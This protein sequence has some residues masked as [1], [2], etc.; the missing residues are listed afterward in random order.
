M[1][2][3]LPSLFTIPAPPSKL[4]PDAYDSFSEE[5]RQAGKQARRQNGKPISGRWHSVL[6]LDL[7]G[8]DGVEI[9]RLLAITPSRVSVIRNSER[10]KEERQ[11]RLA[12]LDSEFFDMK[13]LAFKALRGGLKSEDENIAL[14]ASE[15]WFKVS[16]FGQRAGS[17]T[18]LTAEAIAAALL[19]QQIN[20]TVN[21]DGRR[22]EASI[23]THAAVERPPLPQPED[24][25]LF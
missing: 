13:P 22:E 7:R 3:D 15:Q 20:V 17:E 18:P 5:D 9:G 12:A 21:V 23:S 24:E 2:I 19:S 16:G 10:Y 14:R 11:K 1:S 25:D 6:T 4:R 8:Y